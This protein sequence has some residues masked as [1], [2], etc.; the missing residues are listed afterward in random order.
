MDKKRLVIFPILYGIVLAVKLFN[1]KFTVDPI[2]GINFL[3]TIV[4]VTISYLYAYYP[5]IK[6]RKK[7]M[8]MEEDTDDD[9]TGV[10]NN[11]IEMFGGISISILLIGIFAY[12]T[13]TVPLFSSDCV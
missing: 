5:I 3:F 13:G 9:S 4:T 7:M 8:I 6:R 1:S 11:L 12:S 10:K 2:P